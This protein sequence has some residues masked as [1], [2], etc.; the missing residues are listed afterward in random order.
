MSHSPVHKINIITVTV[1]SL[2]TKLSVIIQYMVEKDIQIALLTE[3]WINHDDCDV[4]AGI[5]N[6]GYD[7]SL[8]PRP[9]GRG[10]GL[11]LLYSRNLGVGK[12]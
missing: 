9:Q 6:C 11:G 3:T 12:K 1:Q 10:G 2:R 5:E 8:I 7:L 4:L